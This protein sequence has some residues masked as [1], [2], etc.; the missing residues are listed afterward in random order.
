MSGEDVKASSRQ[1]EKSP[2]ELKAQEGIEWTAGLNRLPATT[3]CC[4]D[5]RPEVEASGVG[6]GGATRRE[7]KLGN[8]RRARLGDESSRLGSEENP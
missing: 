3:D 1:P 6:S 7:A 4:P 5:Q 8:G 2:Q